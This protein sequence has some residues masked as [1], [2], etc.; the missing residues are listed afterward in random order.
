MARWE[1]NR[2][3][4]RSTAGPGGQEV[5]AGVLD[6]P[7]STRNEKPQGN[8]AGDPGERVR[9]RGVAESAEIALLVPVHED[10]GCYL[11]FNQVEKVS[12]RH[13][14]L[15]EGSAHGATFDRK[16]P[17]VVVADQLQCPQF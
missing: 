12:S 7:E 16:T 11:V 15:L 6:V 3:P 5:L 13:P 14:Q 17:D 10:E 2:P 1:A 4:V 9:E 8:R